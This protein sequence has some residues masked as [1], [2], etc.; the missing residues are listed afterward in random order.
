MSRAL[1]ALLALL[2]LS[3]ELEDPGVRSKRIER[4][5]TA[6]RRARQ[7][8]MATYLRET[9]PDLPVAE[10]CRIVAERI[11]P[12]HWRYERDGALRRAEIAGNCEAALGLAE[13]ER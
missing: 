6:E 7:K 8:L 9:N 2:A 10:R 3:C 5:A 12:L 13:V 11:C 4:E 1:L